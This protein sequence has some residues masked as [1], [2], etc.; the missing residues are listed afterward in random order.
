M[1]MMEWVLWGYTRGMALALAIG[2]VVAVVL[3]APIFALWPGAGTVL[4]V[5]AGGLRRPLE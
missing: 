5:A 4:G 1:I 2:V 3:S